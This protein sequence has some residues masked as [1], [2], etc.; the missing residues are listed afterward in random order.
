MPAGGGIRCPGGKPSARRAARSTTWQLVRISPSAEMT[1]PLP[2]GKNRAVV[3]P[4]S[5]TSAASAI[6]TAAE[7]TRSRT[8]GLTCAAARPAL[9]K[10]TIRLRSRMPAHAG[11]DC[12]DI[13]RTPFAG[14]TILADGAPPAPHG[15]WEGIVGR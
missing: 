12:F 7:T 5:V 2:T 10:E 15:A 14:A 4:F 9:M 1:V 11:R 3:A 13:C 6:S 8:S